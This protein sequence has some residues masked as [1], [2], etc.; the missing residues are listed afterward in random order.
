M[1][2]PTPARLDALHCLVTGANTGIGR[3]A[4]L[5]LARRGATVIVC[6]RTESKAQPVVD[7]ITQSGG[8]ARPWALALDDLDAVA[9]SAEG[10]L[11]EG[12]SIDRLVLNAG[13]AGQRGQTKQGFELAFGVN[14]VGHF[15]FGEMLMPRVRE[16][17]GR[18]V[19][20]A[21]TNHYHPKDIDYAAAR[22][23]TQTVT[24]LR[25]Y[26][27][28]KLAN[29]MTA[30]DWAT[31]HADAGVSAV[32]LNPGRVASDIWRQIPNPF[33]WLFMQ[34]MRTVEQ[35]AY[36]TVHCAALP[37]DALVNGG[38][39]NDCTEV[40][41]NP[42]ALDRARRAELREASLQWVKAWL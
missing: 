41:P 10:L 23:P 9:R 29:V 13:L 30:I 14:H 12:V 39:Y 11:R 8:S 37:R 7:E 38:Y 21:S 4:A 20:V 15:L 26:G 42:A 32:S 24:A 31:L 40:K 19:V 33:R 17:A 28:S 2:Q 6:A 34:T 27:V 36:T 3:T 1:K 25:E 35:G 5:E 16:R 18:V 22:K